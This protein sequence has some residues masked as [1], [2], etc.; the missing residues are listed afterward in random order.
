[1]RT[2]TSVLLL[3]IA[4]TACSP[5][6]SVDN[7]SG[8]DG[9]TTSDAS[10]TLIDGATDPC[11]LCSEFAECAEPASGKE[12][13]CLS[14]YTGDGITC[15]DIDECAVANGGCAATATCANTA[16]DYTCTCPNGT[17]GDGLTCVGN[18]IFFANNR[19]NNEGAATFFKSYDVNDGVVTDHPFPP[20]VND[21]CHCG[22]VSSMIYSSGGSLYNF[23]NEGQR[24][25][26]DWK[27]TSYPASQQRGEYG[28]AVIGS[29]I[30]FVGGRDPQLSKVS[31]YDTESG[32]WSGIN[33]LA[34]YPVGVE[35]PAV[36]AIGGQ[37]FVAGGYITSGGAAA[38][39][40]N[41]ATNAW[42]AL[43]TP[44]FNGAA[45]GASIGTAFFVFANSRLY[46]F[47]PTSGWQD[48]SALP[49]TRMRPAVAGGELYAVGDSSNTTTE[50]VIYRLS[51]TQGWIL[52]KSIPGITMGN[53]PHVG[54]TN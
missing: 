5:V 9:S 29:K 47:T 42:T 41:P 7:D 45:Y 4:L 52:E 25:E 27:P 44:P 43:D 2:P 34:D 37:L 18:S 1:M 46:R 49:G 13:R 36:A 19:N 8:N 50:L 33:Q 26:V 10:A 32:A 28:A 31:F 22:Y 3:T 38:Y 48:I 30:Y 24:F 35:Y 54:G 11:A 12:C 39:R 15:D 14:G 23:A 17:V 53:L 51:A 16:G 20:P 40:Y 21:F 6:S